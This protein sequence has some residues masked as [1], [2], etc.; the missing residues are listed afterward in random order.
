LKK[1][2]S[3]KIL[4]T[5]LNAPKSVLCN[6]C[7]VPGSQ[8]IPETNKGPEKSGK[9][10][11]EVSQETRTQRDRDMLKKF[12]IAC[13]AVATLVTMTVDSAEA[14]NRRYKHRVHHVLTTGSVPKVATKASNAPLAY[15][16]F[17]IRNPS[18]CVGSSKATVAYTSRIKAIMTSVNNSVNTS[19]KYKSDS[20]ENWTLNARYGDCE[21][22]ALTKRSKLIKAGIPA[23]ALRMQVVVTSAGVGHAILVVKTTAGE[24]ALDSIRKT[25]VKNSETGYRRVAIASADPLKW[26]K[27]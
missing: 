21:D 9:K 6:L 16:I 20:Y 10:Q 8:N 2:N 24:F 26:S 22:F 27:L 14:K 15:Q 18:E 4:Q 12:V 1:T 17:C 23:G 7:H 13:A 11:N 3:D 25:I 19:M 5:G